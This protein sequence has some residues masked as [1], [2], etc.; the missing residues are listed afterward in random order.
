MLFECGA[1]FSGYEEDNNFLLIDDCR[2]SHVDRRR[3]ISYMRGGGWIRL[4]VS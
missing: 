2:M 4:L 1:P 3:S